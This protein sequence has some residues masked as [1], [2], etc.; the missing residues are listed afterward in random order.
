MRVAGKL[1][2]GAARAVSHGFNYFMYLFVHAKRGNQA[3]ESSYCLL[4]DFKNWAV[5]DC[6]K[7]YFGISTCAHALCN[8]HILRELEALKENG[9]LWATEMQQFLLELF[10]L[11][12]KAT[13][14]IP[15]KDIWLEKYHQICQRAEQQE[16]PPV[17]SKKGKPKNSKGRNL[18]NR[19]VEHQD[20]IL[21]FAFVESV[22]FTNNQAERDIRSLTTKQKVA[23]SFRTFKG[24]YDTIPY[25]VEM[26]QCQI[27]KP[28]T[29]GTTAHDLLITAPFDKSFHAYLEV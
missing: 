25:F 1:H 11:S 19:L 7:S 21:A 27:Y 14:I 15:N 28:F 18:L 12:Q 23:T 4:N 26:G 16:P 17:K 29:H 2:C 22:P 3:L 10:L 24:A 9:S 8:A 13:V 5:H 6:W 20:G